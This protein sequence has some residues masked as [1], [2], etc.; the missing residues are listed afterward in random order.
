MNYKKDSLEKLLLLIDGVLSRPENEW[1][2]QELAKRFTK[3][4]SI[5]GFPEFAKLL[6]KNFKKKA[7]KIY[8]DFNDV[9][10]RQILIKDNVEMQWYMVLNDPGRFLLFLYYQIELLLNKYCIDFNSYEK[11]N[12]EKN[13]F[14]FKVND[15]FEIVCFDSFYSKD[16]TGAIIKKPLEKINSIWAKLIFFVIDSNNIEWLEKNKSNFSTLIN[17]RNKMSHRGF[18]IE[19][20]SD[21]IYQNLKKLSLLDFSAYS[22]YTNLIT[23]ILSSF[24]NTHSINNASS[25]D[26]HT[27]LPGLKILGKVNLDNIKRK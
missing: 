27:K 12:A 16:R 22:F 15:G 19:D 23:K 13:R 9:K 17:T 10:L 21:Y 11:I 1:F 4:E 7:K 5:L 20:E 26:G 25:N 2:R 8:S 6:R 3:N 14:Y 24:K 18:E